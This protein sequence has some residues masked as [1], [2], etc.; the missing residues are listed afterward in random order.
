M[1]RVNPYVAEY[2]P[3]PAL[4][5]PVETLVRATGGSMRLRPGGGSK[6]RYRI[7]LHGRTIVV[8]PRTGY[9]ND[10]DTL[11]DTDGATKPDAFWMLVRLFDRHGVPFILDESTGEVWEEGLTA[12]QCRAWRE[13]W[14]ARRGTDAPYAE[15]N[16]YTLAELVKIWHGTRDHPVKSM[17]MNTFLCR[18]REGKPGR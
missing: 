11:L 12:F 17:N 16:G 15:C 8:D 14:A 10:L 3:V 4:Y 7:D 13:F 6:G 18:C 5:Q 2:E 1:K 9:T